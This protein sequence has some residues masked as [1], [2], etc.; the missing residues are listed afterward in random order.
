MTDEELAELLTELASLMRKA[1][2]PWSR[3]A[4]RVAFGHY[5][6]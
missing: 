6:E 3:E 2:E 1:G 4:Y 5:P